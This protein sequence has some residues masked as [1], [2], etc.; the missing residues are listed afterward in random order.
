MSV[1]GKLIP[2]Y[3]AVEEMVRAGG[4]AIRADQERRTLQTKAEIEV[5]LKTEVGRREAEIRQWEEKKKAETEIYLQTEI[6]RRKAKIRDEE[7]ES[8]NKRRIEFEKHRVE[9][10]ER[11]K[12]FE[13]EIHKDVMSF[14]VN[15]Q[16]KIAEWQRAFNRKLETE[17]EEAMTD[18]VPRMLEQAGKFRDN[19]SVYEQYTDRIFKVIDNITQSIQSDQEYF[20]ERLADLSKRPEQLTEGLKD[21]NRRLTLS[22][23]E[24]TRRLDE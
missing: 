18:R 7:R 19:E 12:K 11:I 4:D 20:R 8:V 15:E 10:F 3:S 16:K 21:L 6:D 1:L 14:E 5:Y 13:I 2:F 24:P 22:S 17:L 23:A 9:L